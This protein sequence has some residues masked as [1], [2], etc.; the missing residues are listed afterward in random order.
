MPMRLFFAFHANLRAFLIK[1]QLTE[2]ALLRTHACFSEFIM[3]MLE[4]CDW[5]IKI[6]TKAETEFS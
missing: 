1:K 2:A 4:Y 6:F 5:V 3:K